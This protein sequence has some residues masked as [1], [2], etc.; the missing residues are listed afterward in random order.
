M[1]FFSQLKREEK[2]AI[3]LLSIGTFLEYFDLMLYVHMSI[4]LN[5]L[6]YPQ[7]D[8][9][10]AKL[11]S[12]L[13]FCST[14]V[15][16]PFGALLF[17][18][19]GDNI[20]RKS[21]VIITTAMMSL[22]CLIMYTLP[23]YA[24]IG[25]SAS[26]LMTLCRMM[27]G[28]S[29]MG[30]IIGAELYLTET[31]ERPLVF[32]VVGF[33]TI[34]L[35]F[36]A[37][38]ALAVAS[39]VTNSEFN[40][41][42]AFLI[43]AVIALVG[44][45]GRMRLRETPEFVDAKCKYQKLIEKIANDKKNM[46][47]SFIV[48][49]FDRFHNMQTISFQ[50]IEKQRKIANETLTSFI[51]VAIYLGIYKVEKQLTL[52]CHQVLNG[53]PV[54]LSYLGLSDK[55]TLDPKSYEIKLIA[56]LH[57]FNKNSSSKIEIDIVKK[58][59]EC[60]K[61][62]HADQNRKSGEPYYTHPIEVARL[63]IQYSNTGYRIS[64]NTIVSA[65]LHDVV[66]DSDFT[67]EMVELEFGKDI[68]EVV[69]GVTRVRHDKKLSS[70]ALL[71]LVYNRVES[72]KKEKVDWKTSLSY[73][74]LES[75]API[76]F[77]L[78]YV[79]C[80][81]ILKDKFGYSATEIIHH[82]FIINMVDVVFTIVLVLLSYKIYPLKILKAK[83]IIYFP[84]ILISPYLLENTNSKFVI[85]IIQFYIVIFGV[86]VLTASPIFYKNFPVF[87]RF[88]YTSFMYALSRASMYVLTSFGLVYLTKYF[89]YY[90]LLVILVP[91][92]IGYTFGLLHFE[93]LE[94]EAGNY[95]K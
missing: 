55:K 45:V 49:L 51:S 77:Y 40:W 7:S 32:P 84:F 60:A 12:A 42:N 11:L 78:I 90:G 27:Q 44:V 81:N 28:M 59:I 94:K 80:G 65:I 68:A 38:A 6:F 88:T 57:E 4:F 25:I 17:G 41:R 74:F 9:N 10:T 33:L 46:T 70:V 66:E 92:M 3:G 93:K 16:R 50:S 73:F 83:L 79:F 75:P 67:K 72:L 34:S 82:N 29:S 91:V 37:M 1:E 52:L 64:T 36:G 8:P 54:Q 53:Q 26:W 43:G 61:I 39:L 19:M 69:D 20:G 2:E 58:A 14:F 86:G 47:D 31:I 85:L 13:G 62:Y 56:E 35:G 15:L 30:E 5:E 89:G 23:T 76:S 24:Q 95:P 18:W 22:S 87:K 48:K 71:E 63:I 21:T